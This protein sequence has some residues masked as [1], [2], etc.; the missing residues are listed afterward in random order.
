[1]STFFEETAPTMPKILRGAHDSSSNLTSGNNFIWAKDDLSKSTNS[2][3]SNATDFSNT[4][5]VSNKWP[6]QFLN[7]DLDYG[8]KITTAGKTVK[9]TNSFEMRRVSFVPNPE[10][11]DVQSS[12]KKR[13]LIG[14]I[15]LAVIA[16]TCALYGKFVMLS[17]FHLA[18]SNN[19]F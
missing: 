15:I 11:M 7:D 10:I 1:M 19:F 6:F 5:Q 8:D 2:V 9:A 17:F 14:S 18:F 12:G 13:Y 3:G 4:E 16:A